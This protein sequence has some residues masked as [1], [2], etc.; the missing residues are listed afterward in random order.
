[1]PANPS[2]RAEAR[3]ALREIRAAYGRFL[4]ALVAVALGVGALVGVRGFSQSFRG[5]L[6]SQARTLI[7]GDLLLRA[8]APE[9]EALTPRQQNA[10]AYLRRRHVRWT[11]ITESVSMVAGQAGA[12]PILTS[13]KAVDPRRYPFAGRVLTQPPGAL[14]RL[15]DHAVLASPDLLLRSGLKPGARLRVGDQLFRI[16]GVDISEPDLLAGGLSVGP[17]A[18]LTERGLRRAGIVVFGSQASA[19]LVFSLR[20]GAPPLADVESALHRAFPQARIIDARHGNP[21]VERGVDH[22]TTFLSLISLFALMVGSLGVANAM[23]AHLQLRMDAIATLKVLG[24]RGGQILRMYGLQAVTLGAIGSVLGL[25][26]AAGVTLAFPP[27]LAPFFPGLPRWNWS[28]AAAAEGIAAGMLVTLLFSLPTLLAARRIRPA[29]ILRRHMSDSGAGAP[30]SRRDAWI[31]GAVLLCG[32]A[33]LA[34]TLAGGTSPRGMRVAGYFLAAVG[35]GCLALGAFA[36]LLLRILRFGIERWAAQGRPPAALRHGLANVY[37]PGSQSLAILIS[38]GLGIAF[39]LSVFLLQRSILL[40]LDRGTPPGVANVFLLDIPQSQQ[41]QVLHF[42]LEAPGRLAAPELLRTVRARLAHRGIAVATAAAAPLG[43]RVTAGRWWRRPHRA[44]PRVAINRYLATRMHVRLGQRLQLAVGG[45]S[46]EVRVSA[47]YSPE[48]QRLSA[49]V[50]AFVSPGPL[51]GLVPDIN[52]GVRMNPAAIP[53]LERAL[54]QRFPTITVINLADVIERVR[55]VVGQ[56]TRVVHFI[57]LF[58]VLAAAFVLASAVS[59]TR[60]RRLREFAVLKTC[61]ATQPAVAR[62]LT[63]EFAFLGII[64]GAAGA[65]L[66]LI[67]SSL[68][69]RRLLD[70]SLRLSW[71]T[72]WPYAAV[73]TAACTVLAVAAGW[74][75]GAPLLRQ[76]PLAVLRGE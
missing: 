51:A 24:A 56:V 52:G 67:F 55:E 59:G 12:E 53:D 68:L 5:L 17:R 27:L 22:A 66:A 62:M 25:L 44:R 31:A 65:L 23:N 47:L 49:R 36:W 63:A 58:A 18:L 14:A 2:W 74:L 69:A 37:R 42:L 33:A 26:F 28:W 61:G 45:R 35:G 7:A 73:A 29:H 46:V 21:T 15:G 10:L 8:P 16:A 54:F 57:S 71:H 50:G 19:R 41:A 60:N 30:S 75:A 34:M 4:F 11:R 39:S 64:A 1:M 32:L 3:I 72:D 76:K 9:L 43:V 13:L 38:L 70:L 20:P 40:D 48:P 6:L